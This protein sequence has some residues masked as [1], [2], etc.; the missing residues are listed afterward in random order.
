MDVNSNETVDNFL[1][2]MFE[3]EQIATQCLFYLDFNFNQFEQ[4]GN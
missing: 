3:N 1:R 2:K 4:E